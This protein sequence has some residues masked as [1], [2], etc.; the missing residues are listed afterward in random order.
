LL[1][2]G[3]RIASIP[4]SLSTNTF[5]SVPDFMPDTRTH[6]GPAPEDEKLFAPQTWPT[7]RQAVEDLR[8]LLNRGYALRSAA[9][10][11]GNRY[12]LTARQ[13][14]AVSRSVCTDEARRRRRRHEVAP[15]Q[16]HD[17][18]VWLDGFNVLTTIEAALSGAVL[19]SG[20]DGS[21]RDLASVYARH[22]EVEETGPALELLGTVLAAW[23]VRCCHWWLDRPVSN[24]GRLKRKMLELATTQGWDWRVELVFNPDR[25]LAESR[26]IVATSDSV[27]LDRCQRWINLTH[28]AIAQRIPHAR[29]VDLSLAPMH[30]GDRE[31]T[32]TRRTS[33]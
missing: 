16:L 29:I 19:L 31:E 17:G 8:W 12:T 26:E 4:S 23:G 15:A 27:I 22:H 10:L 30:L 9:E 7:L 5:S 25:V 6:R 20:C 28:L 24:S 11:V 13:R 33:L 21:I 2:L 3:W 32:E 18:T 1:N 14:I